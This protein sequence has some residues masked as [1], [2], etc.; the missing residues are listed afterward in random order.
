MEKKDI[1]DVLTVVVIALS[2]PFALLMKP[3]SDLLR[4]R[5]RGIKR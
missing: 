5:D 2:C 1:A 3:F 4:E